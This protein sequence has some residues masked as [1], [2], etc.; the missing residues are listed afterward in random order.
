M[1]ETR[2]STDGQDRAEEG[3]DVELRDVTSGVVEG[4]SHLAD[5]A[6]ERLATV[7]DQVAAVGDRLHLRR[8][9]R[10][11]G[12]PIGPRRTDWAKVGAIGVGAAVLAAGTAGAVRFGPPAARRAQDAA[13][14]IREGDDE[15]AGSAART[16]EDQLGDLSADE[17][18]LVKALQSLEEETQ[19]AIAS[20]GSLER[21]AGESE[22]WVLTVGLRSNGASANGIRT[23]RVVADHDGSLRTSGPL[24]PAAEGEGEQ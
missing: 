22:G 24:D 6:G 13:S 15:A 17:R 2:S 7:G 14:G 18:A 8:R 4:G 3:A 20:I 9:T 19:S 21:E 5:A 1:A 12:L 10:I 16:L 11:L 23:Y